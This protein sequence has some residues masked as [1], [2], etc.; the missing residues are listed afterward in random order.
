M[1]HTIINLE[2][3]HN[4]SIKNMELIDHLAAIML[5]QRWMITLIINHAKLNN[6]SDMSSKS[7]WQPIS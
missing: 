3:G 4:I 1:K 7:T 5:D 6:K 2:V